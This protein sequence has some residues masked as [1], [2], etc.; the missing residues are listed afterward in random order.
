MI[1]YEDLLELV[2]KRRSIR[3]FKPDSL[4]DELVDKIIEAARWAPS[5][6]NSQ[7]WQFVIVRDKE[8]REKIHGFIAEMGE[9]NRKVELLRPPELR[10]HGAH[11]PA[12]GQPGYMNAPVFIIACGDPRGSMAYPMATS[13]TRAREHLISGMANA[14]LQ[15]HLAVTA[16]GLASQ[17]ISA[18]AHVLT[19]TR[20]KAMLGIPASLDIYDTMAVGYPAGQPRPRLVREREEITHRE[21]FDVSKHMTDEQHR[22]FIIRIIGGDA[23]RG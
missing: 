1:N 8:T 23:A 14:F 9:L 4:P 15:M 6:A 16:L 18:T 2:K 12:G 11:A 19:Q 7:P 20:I 5:G 17:W 10:H 13:L 21:K 3:R 22:Q